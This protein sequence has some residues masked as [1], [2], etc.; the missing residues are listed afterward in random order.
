MKSLLTIRE[1]DIVAGS[2]DV[3]TS[4]FRE[5]RA[6][7]AVLLDDNAQV[8]MLNVSKHGYHKL[9]GGGIEAGEDILSALERELMEEVGCSRYYY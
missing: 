4:S 2:A 3:D 6:A 9:P 1:Q 8:H 7:R 5:R